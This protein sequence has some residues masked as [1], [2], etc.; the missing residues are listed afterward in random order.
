MIYKKNTLY[1]SEVVFSYDVELVA[2]MS[3]TESD[4]D[5]KSV[6][7]LKK[8]NYEEHTEIR[9]QKT[10]ISEIDDHIKSKA[11]VSKRKGNAD[12]YVLIKDKL[13]III[14][15]KNPTENIE[16]GIED[17]I[18]YAECL[19]EKNY[20][21]RIAMS[22][23]GKHC[24]LKVYN[25]NKNEWVP[26]LINGIEINSFPS[27]DLLDIIYKFKGITNIIVTEDSESI[28]IQ[29]VIRGLKEIFRNVPHLQNDNQKTIDFTISF[30]ALKSILEKHGADLGKNWGD[31]DVSEQKILKEK[32]KNAVE[33]INDNLKNGYSEIFRIKEDKKGKVSAF[34]F[35]NVINQFDDKTKGEGHL[36]QIFKQLNELPQLHSSKFDL[37]GEIYQSLMDKD[38]RKRFGQFFTPRH[39]IK[40]L[41]RLFYEE[42]LENLVGNIK[43]NKSVNPKKI[44]DP[45]C[46]T[47]GFLTESFKYFD[48]KFV[49]INVADLA[50]K[51]IHGFDLYPANTV[52]SRINMYLAGDGFSDISSLNS[53][54][55]L[56]NE[57]DYILTNPPFGKGDFYVDKSIVSRRGKK[58]IF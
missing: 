5:S 13:K 37:F 20:D 2:D 54:T 21:I 52:R 33:D 19:L 42:E 11:K 25:S 31:F 14:D 7:I 3:L 23:N 12:V 29:N 15:N 34:D 16:K 27:K 9:Q 55:D 45:A 53:L 48:D 24:A 57:Y 18:F 47:G 41:I 56:N 17:A 50:K 44:C 8:L 10:N 39:L 32:I 6:E 46:G 26:F 40:T 30:I 51:S 4:I 58:L 1:C 49:G 35:L 28:N 38:T 43:N 22:Y 36:I